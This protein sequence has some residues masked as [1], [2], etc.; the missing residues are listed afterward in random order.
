MD[1]EIAVLM[2]AGMGMRMRPITDSIPK[3]LVKVRGTPMIETVIE[4]IRSWG[5]SEIYVVTGYLSDMFDYLVSKYPGI[6]LVPNH[7]Y[8]TVNNISSIKAVTSVLRNRNAFI[9]E[10][11]LYVLDQALFS[12][13]LDHSCYFG[14]YVPRHSDDRVFDR[15]ENGR[16][17]RVGKGGDNC[18]NMCGISY[19]LNRD[20]SIIA[21]A[22]DEVCLHPGYEEMFWDEVVNMNLGRLDIIVH[23]IN[24]DQITEIDS[25]EELSH[26]VLLRR[27]GSRYEC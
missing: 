15:D 19:F 18:Y 10:A 20:A 2:A 13:R 24:N 16:I 22:I 23:P 26:T 8:R 7:E 1:K 4:G 17:T 14:K 5:I 21:D 27:A 12:A 9:C 6:E 25:V 11:D 3:P